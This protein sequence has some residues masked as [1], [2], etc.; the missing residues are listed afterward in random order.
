MFEITFHWSVF[1]IGAWFLQ[2]FFV[3][4]HQYGEFNLSRVKFFSF[5]I[6][7]IPVLYYMGLLF[8]GVWLVILRTAKEKK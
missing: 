4:G 1:I 8:Y 7:G 3:I 2:I 5:L 6:L